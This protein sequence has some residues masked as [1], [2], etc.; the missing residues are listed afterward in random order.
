MDRR[1]KY[2]IARFSPLNRA[3]IFHFRMTGKI[4]RSPNPEPRFARLAWDGSRVSGSSSR[5]RDASAMWRSS[6]PAKLADYEPLLKMGP[7]PHGLTGDAARRAA[8]AGDDGV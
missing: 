5:T 7:E 3:V 4:I 1:G 8:V 2:L 6:T